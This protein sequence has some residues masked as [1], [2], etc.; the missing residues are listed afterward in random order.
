MEGIFFECS[1]LTSLD[2][3]KF[4][5]NLVKTMAYMFSGCKLLRTLKLHKLVRIRNLN[6]G[7]NLNYDYTPVSIFDTNLLVI[8]VSHM[9]SD[10]SSLKSLDL[11][12]FKSS[13]VV[14]MDYMFSGIFKFFEFI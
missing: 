12:N 4:N 5:I 14:C 13:K 2:I 1:T 9:F 11:S 7:L 6:M 8:N 10:C 3:S